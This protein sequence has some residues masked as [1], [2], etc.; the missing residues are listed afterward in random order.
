MGLLLN[1]IILINEIIHYDKFL[2]SS[3]HLELKL[4][5][6]GN[7]NYFKGSYIYFILVLK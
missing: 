3:W 2:Q 7:S 6:K 1:T 5:I 4:E